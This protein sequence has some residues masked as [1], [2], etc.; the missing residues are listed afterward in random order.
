MSTQS[1]VSDKKK[2]VSDLLKAVRDLEG[3]I[4]RNSEEIRK[5][6]ARRQKAGGLEFG[7]KQYLGNEIEELQAKSAKAGAKKKSLLEDKKK[8]DA[9]LA[10]A[11]VI[12]KDPAGFK[13]KHQGLVRD[14]DQRAALHNKEISKNNAKI[15]ELQRDYDRAGFTDIAAKGYIRDR[16]K[17]LQGKNASLKK[18]IEDQ[19]KRRQGFEA[20]IALVDKITATSLAGWGV[21]ALGGL[22]VAANI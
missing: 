22:F 17:A 9:L 3:Q 10:E 20:K 12:A 2:V 21:A 11:L 16:Q 7:K 4:S 18:A 19:K 6:Q 15:Q 8:A 1:Y 13:R 5:I 14:A